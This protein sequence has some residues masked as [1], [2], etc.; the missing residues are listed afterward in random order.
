MWDG[1]V[2][3]R[4]GAGL[5]SDRRD[6]DREVLGVCATI[7]SGLLLMFVGAVW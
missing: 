7:C 5:A 2:G 6:R 3:R 1:Q 4:K